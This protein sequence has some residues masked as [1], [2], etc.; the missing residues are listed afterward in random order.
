MQRMKKV[1]ESEMMLQKL[2]LDDAEEC[3]AIKAKLDGEVQVGHS[4]PVAPELHPSSS[5]PGPALLTQ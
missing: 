2:R 1:E 4:G 5:A 3:N